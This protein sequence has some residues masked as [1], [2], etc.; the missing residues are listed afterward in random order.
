MQADPKQIADLTAMN[1]LIE[2]DLLPFSYEQSNAQVLVFDAEDMRIVSANA[3]ALSAL[4]TDMRALQKLN[5]YDLIPD[6]SKVRTDRILK[7]LSKRACGQLT[8]LVHDS[9]SDRAPVEV[10][11]R[12]VAGKRNSLIA[13]IKPL[14]RFGAV[15]KK[16]A[17]AEER[18][19]VAIE[20]LSD[21]FVFYDKDDRL[22]VCNN[23]YREIY[24][25]SAPAIV[26]G[27]TF[28]E[29]LRYGLERNQYSLGFNTKEAW[30]ARRLSEHRN[31][32][33]RTEQRLADGRW[34]HHEPKAPRNRTSP[35]VSIR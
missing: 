8:F 35:F 13:T 28:E 21:G 18:L 29:I 15:A 34:L 1:E 19:N 25:E 6:F 24:S 27:A 31:C 23:S 17:L 22:V 3:V 7:R 2:R 4:K 30:L 11:L 5:L 9:I 14:R 20:A 33:P 16:A 26:K 10:L 32:N 12:F